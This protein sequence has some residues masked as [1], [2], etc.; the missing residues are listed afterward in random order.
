MMGGWLGGSVV[1]W[2]RL[3]GWEDF[4]FHVPG[5]LYCGVPQRVTACSP[6][7]ISR[8]TSKSVILHNFTWSCASSATST[9]P[10][11]K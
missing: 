7:E 6:G 4:Y 8:E 10:G 1:L 11:L 2:W 9:F 3:C 5:A